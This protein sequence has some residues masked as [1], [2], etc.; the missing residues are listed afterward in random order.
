LLE[1][2]VVDSSDERL[3]PADIA[4]FKNLS[5]RYLESPRSVC[6]QRNRGINAARGDWIFLCDDDI[7]VTV[8]YIGTLVEHATR[9]P[10]AGAITG[11]VVELENGRW[12]QAPPPVSAR[13]LI[14]AY[15]FQLGIH[16]EIQARG[17]VTDRV[18]AYYRRK[19]NHISRAGRPVITSFAEPYFRTPVFM[20]GAALVKREWLLAS[21]YDERLDP[22]GYGD[23][24]GVAIGFPPEGIHVVTGASV[25]HHRELRNRQPRTVAY[26]RG[27]LAL[28]SF[29]VTRKELAA[30][31]TP[32]FMLWS[33]VGQA[34]FHAVKRNPP[35]ARAA[36]STLWT[37]V[38]RR[39][40]FLQGRPAR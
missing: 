9:H 27:M 18:A 4:G 5:V 19:G 3:A 6:V 28:H 22:P 7:E 10:E 40:P 33:L 17:I 2:V 39:N 16:G 23:N 34:I 29:I 11:V 38:R 20:L 31:A 8:D 26:A 12:T 1:T 32:A 13:S 35:M 24:Y 37:I 25:R 14:W 36:L 15:L 21:P 30:V